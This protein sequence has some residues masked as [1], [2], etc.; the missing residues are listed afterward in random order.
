MLRKEDLIEYTKSFYKLNFINYLFGKF[1]SI[2]IPYTVIIML[3][4]IIN[5]SFNIRY[6]LILVFL[7]YS[8]KLYLHFTVLKV[9]STIYSKFMEYLK[10]NP[11]VVLTNPNPNYNEMQ[12]VIFYNARV[13]IQKNLR[14]TDFKYWLPIEQ[15]TNPILTRIIDPTILYRY[16]YRYF[17][18]ENHYNFFCEEFSKKKIRKMLKK[19][20]ENSLF[21]YSRNN[22]GHSS[23]SA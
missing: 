13:S 12:R 18:I 21:N 2:V 1:A 4:Q 16:F 11:I 6:L 7:I 17:H 8:I 10:N 9:N 22:S 19:T 14:N 20:F 23:K 5:G 3:Y 15:L